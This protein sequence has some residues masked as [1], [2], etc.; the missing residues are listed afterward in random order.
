MKIELKYTEKTA[1]NY[2]MR[3]CKNK[4]IYSV[5]LHI[6]ARKDLDRTEFINHIRGINGV[7]EASV[8]E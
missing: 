5:T 3:Y 6:R 7:V 2:V 1:L 8:Y 4:S